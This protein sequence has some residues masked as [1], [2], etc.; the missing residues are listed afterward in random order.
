MKNIFYAASLLFTLNANA[1]PNFIGALAVD[2][3]QNG[4]IIYK[5]DMPGGTSTI[6]HQF[7]NL[8]P[9]KP[10]TGLT[11]GDGNWL[12]GTLRYNGANNHGALF[13][14]QRDGNGFTVLHEMQ[15]VYGPNTRPYFH[16]DGKIYF[17]DEN[18]LLQYDPATGN[19]IILGS[20]SSILTRNL[21]I[22]ADDWIYL[23]TGFGTLE[24]IKTDGSNHTVLHSFNFTT[25][26]ANAIPGVTEVPGDTLFG[27]LLTGGTLGAGAIY[28]IKKDGTGFTIHQQFDITNGFD[29]M[30]AQ[31]ESRLILYDGRLFGT[32]TRGGSA[33]IGVLYTI[34]LDG[35]GYRVLA[36]FPAGFIGIGDMPTADISITSNARI[37]GAYYQFTSFPTGYQRFFKVDTSGNNFEGFGTVNQR[38]NGHFNNSLLLTDDE[39]IFFTTQSMGR[40]DGGVFNQ[41]DTAGNSSGLFH[42]GASPNG[43]RPGE[44]MKA[45]DGRLYGTTLFGGPSGNGTI[46]SIRA[47][48]TG[49]TKLYEFNDGQGYEPTGKLLEA[50]DGKLYG[51]LAWGGIVGGGALFRIDKD[52]NNFQILYDFSDLANGYSP[53]GNLVEDGAGFLYGSTNYASTGYGVVF[54][55]NKNGTG[56]LVLRNFNLPDIGF[57]YGGLKLHMG[58][59]YGIGY[60]G[61][62]SSLGGVFRISTD[63]T[64]Y[65]LL[66]SFSGTADGANPFAPPIVANDGKLYG[67]AMNGGSQSVGTIYSLDLN[68]SNFAVIKHLTPSDVQYPQNGI[69]QASDGFLYG[70][71]YANTGTGVFKM[72]LTGSSYSIVKTFDLTTEGQTGVS[73]FELSSSSLPVV[74]TKFQVQ[75]RN[76]KGWLNWQTAEEENSKLFDIERSGDGTIFKSIGMVQASGNSNNLSSYS[77]VDESPL[78][79]INYYRLKQIDKNERFTYSPV[80]T[81]FFNRGGSIIL[82][83]NPAV[84]QIQLQFPKIYSNVVLEIVNSE[85]RLMRKIA[86]NNSDQL[87]I[88]IGNFPAGRYIIRIYANN[89]VEV[90][91]FIKLTR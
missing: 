32:T 40:H 77:F 59:L 72:D 13:K 66:H 64:G 25:E 80:K 19:V 89:K 82:Y 7:N 47:D 4:G 23:T 22:D 61:G 5:L 91:S 37:I 53:I 46:F 29:P 50:S 14:I 56:Y 35:S 36:D 11:G 67:G 43:F 41:G 69:I 24:K 84:N 79:G 75:K 10:E 15:N 54:K 33:G 57:P 6:V 68:G 81:L 3:P 65:Q 34:N 49:Y 9:H 8:F 39:T 63:G 45:S 44:L 31:P 78:V 52:G 58:F 74:L 26:G 21:L 86:V 20:V 12:Y 42:F 70:A 90:V 48:G 60:L 76:E 71:G 18:E 87:E 88:P 85:G 62:T 27:V 2:G 1:Q 83:P 16:T 55:M 28:S 17:S 73:L 51:A 30:G 38:E